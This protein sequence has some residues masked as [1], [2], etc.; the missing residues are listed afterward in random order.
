[1]AKGSGKSAI[2]IGFDRRE[3]KLRVLKCPTGNVNPSILEF[4]DYDES[5]FHNGKEQQILH[6]NISE[7]KEKAM[8]F[9]SIYLVLP[10]YCVA[11]DVINAPN[12]SRFKMAGALKVDSEGM[13]DNYN[14]LE[15]HYFQLSSN[16]SYSTYASVIMHKTLLAEIKKIFANEKIVLTGITYASNS[17]LNC[18]F[19][20]N[21][22][23]KGKSFLFVDINENDTRIVVSSK[24]KTAGFSTLP[25]GY[26]MIASETVVNEQTLWDHDV[27]EL[28][29]INAQE[30]A[31]AKKLTV[32]VAENEQAN[33]ELSD[34][35]LD[36]EPIENAPY[37]N[38]DSGA[39]YG[40]T[41][42]EIEEQ[43]LE[44][45]EKKKVEQLSTAA[46]IKVFTRKAPKKLPKFMQR[47]EPQ[48]EEEMVEENFRSILKRIL[49][50]NEFNQQNKNLN[51]FEYVLLNIPEKFAFLV[52]RLS[53]DEQNKVKFR[54]VD[55]TFFGDNVEA[56]DLAGA[57]YMK[58]YNQ[59]NNF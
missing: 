22:K 35:E 20:A 42:E 38:K 4:I 6:D 56:L 34:V 41:E 25:F 37:F 30:T 59:E 8:G 26:N 57:L 28:A 44:E 43:R 50:Y 55:P 27:A 16:K 58:S 48:N 3:P 2:I 14:D 19:A 40:L 53:N 10:D 49:L 33:S 36:E 17:V 39:E 12:L 23:N 1:M 54:R 15:I 29:V 11:V 45:E 47:P 21:G 51:D 13:Y 32:A 46:K 24:G 9:E 5:L 18:A 52:D 31:K 7:I